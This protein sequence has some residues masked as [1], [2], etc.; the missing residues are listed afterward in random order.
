MIEEG[1]GGYCCYRDGYM[2]YRSDRCRVC[3]KVDGS[4]E[5]VMRWCGI[6][7]SRWAFMPR[8]ICRQWCGVK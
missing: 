4:I 7:Y 6:E 5:S 3:D 8:V 1:G 2:G